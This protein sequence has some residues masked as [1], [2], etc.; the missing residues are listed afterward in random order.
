MIACEYSG[1]VRDAFSKKGHDAWS[2]DLRPTLSE[3]T[4]KE[5]KHLQGNV[6]KYINDYWDLMIGFQPCTYLSNVNTKWRGDLYRFKKA[7]EAMIFFTEL[8]DAPIN[9]IALENPVG[10]LN[11][12][13]RKPDQIIHPYYFGGCEQKRTCLWLKNLPKLK[14]SKTETL[15][16]KRSHALLHDD[17]KNNKSNRQTKWYNNNKSQ[18]S[19]LFQSIADAM[20]NQWG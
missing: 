13:Y 5:G 14:H 3:M 17:F 20:A 11:T 19:I 15:F 7:A 12:C 16:S 2:C 9:K 4:K 8:F 10:M 1:K 6:L 18:R